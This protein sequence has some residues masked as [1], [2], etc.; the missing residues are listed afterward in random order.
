[1][2]GIRWFRDEFVEHI[3][4]KY[5]RTGVCQHLNE[6]QAQKKAGQ[7]VTPYEQPFLPVRVGERARQRGS[8]GN[9]GSGPHQ[10]LPGSENNKGSGVPGS[11]PIGNDPGSTGKRDVITMQR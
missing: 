5:C 10:L 6:I 4:Q 7:P 3:E 2:G 11:G 9:A 8:A 1:M